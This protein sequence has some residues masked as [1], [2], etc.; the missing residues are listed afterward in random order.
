MNNS[1]LYKGL[2][3]LYDM[4]LNNYL[5]T[6]AINSID[7]EICELGIKRRIPAPT[8]REN[9]VFLGNY[10]IG[11]ISIGGIGGAIFGV[12]YGFC[13]GRGFWGKIGEAF[14][15]LIRFAIIFG[16]IGIVLGIVIGIIRKAIVDKEIEEEYSNNYENYRKQLADDERRVKAEIRQ[17]NILTGQ[18]TNLEHRLIA[19][20]DKLDTYYRAMGVDNKYRNLV[21][22]GYM[23]EFMRLGIST[24]LEGVDGLY[25]LVMR[26]LRMDQLQYTLDEISGKLD[27]IIDK[28]RD[29]Y[30]ELKGINKKCDTL[31]SL[32]LQE[33]QNAAKRN[34]TLNSIENNTRIAAYNSERLAKEVEF[35]NFMIAYSQL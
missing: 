4:E 10:F 24:K 5:M 19:A 6:R 31:V 15:G 18:R 13:V 28:Q 12:I 30:N 17:S 8:K 32:S 21:P 34:Q 29:I 9:K 16:I 2:T 11:G 35:Q 1:Q 27:M 7:R 33:A 20:T 25:Y 26:E 14:G 23:C 22:I 3:I